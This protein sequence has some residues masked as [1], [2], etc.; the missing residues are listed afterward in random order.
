MKYSHENCPH[1]KS[2]N[3]KCEEGITITEDFRIIPTKEFLEE[4]DEFSK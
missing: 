1:P 4:E 3:K 2:L